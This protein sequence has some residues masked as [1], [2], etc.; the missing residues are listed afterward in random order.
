[1]GTLAVEQVAQRLELS[2]DVLKGPSRTAAPRQQTL[3]ATLDW[4][5]N[6]LSEA[7]RGLF[8]RLSVFAGGWTLE[9]AEAVCSGGDI[10]QEDI[11][12]LLGGLVDKSL[13]VAGV[14][15]GREVRYRMLVPIRQYALE[16]LE[17]S[18]EAE[19][20]QGRH[21]AFYFAMSEEA[22]PDLA[23]VHQK[24]W[25]ER[26]EGDHDNLREALSWVLERGETDLGLRFC[27]ALWRFWLLG[28]YWS[29]GIRWLD[30]ALAGS[31]SA[32]A[33]V[34]ALEGMGWLTQNRGD[35]EK[36]SAAYEEM[37]KLSRELDAKGDIATA[38]NSLGTL[39]LTR[40]DNER[41]RMLLEENMAVLQE[42]EDEGN[43]GTTL[44]KYHA[45][46]LLGGLAINQERDYARAA[47]LWK[48]SLAFA[49]EVGDTRRVGQ[50]L[51]N[52]G[53]AALLQGDHDRATAF[54][55][56]SL[57]V[58]YELGS[59]G[60]DL[61]PENLVNL[62]LAALSQGHHERVRAM[63][64]EALAVSQSR[65]RKA[66][67]INA[68]EGMAS[69]TAALGEATRAAHLW[70]AAQAS[71]EVTEIALPPGERTLHEPYLAAASSQLGEAVWEEALAEGGG[72]SL[73]EAADYALSEETDQPE[74]VIPQDPSAYDPTGT[75]SRREREV[76]LLVARGLTNRQI[77]TELSISERTAGN[78]VARIL[79]KLRLRSRAQVATWAAEHQLTTSDPD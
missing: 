21:A 5:H 4:S 64:K 69:L 37:L 34:K 7:E 50:A 19:E 70:G 3:R 13:G 77:S 56:E 51:S 57:A 15:T 43:T 46:N 65:G 61:V 23:G 59:A 39:A 18:G 62:G 75:L 29:E 54:G 6:L 41:A 27:G 60:A 11:L 72:M 1:M 9:A 49:R 78:H 2:L 48:E 68:L 14:S 55:E 40:G 71:R 38:L 67:I 24:V 74:V 30:Q 44:K 33:R 52:L 16:K 73:E 12:D 58:A 42:L 17:E 53:Y 8:R 28:G 22:E 36:A 76:A 32:P 26:L 10:D 79:S 47:T 66:T 20:V 35:T 63:L 25:V 31:E 45:L